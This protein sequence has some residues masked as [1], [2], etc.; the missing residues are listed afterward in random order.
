MSGA[1]GAAGRDGK[2]AS[3]CPGRA[4]RRGRAWRLIRGTAGD[5]ARLAAAAAGFV[6]LNVACI[7]YVEMP[8]AAACAWLPARGAALLWAARRSGVR[9][10]AT[11]RLRPLAAST[12]LRVVACAPACLALQL[13]AVVLLARTGLAGALREPAPG[14]LARYA[15]QPGGWA[16]GLLF[17]VALAPL[18]EELCFRGAVQ[19]PLERRLGRAPAIAATAGLFAW[20]HGH[21]AAGLANVLFAGMAG[22]AVA[23]T[24]SLW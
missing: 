4:K 10:R 20:M 19:R 14:A 3:A 17:T 7:A 18:L 5:A 22:Y 6:L 8:P 2:A 23:A 21:G 1:R 9:R 16:P 24:G 13:A 11:L 15:A 12:C